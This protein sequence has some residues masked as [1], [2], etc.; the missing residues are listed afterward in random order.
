MTK[1]QRGRSKSGEGM[2][3]AWDKYRETDAEYFKYIAW[4]ERQRFDTRELV[5]N[6]P[7]FVGQVNLAR[8][9]MMYDLYA[10]VRELSG[11]IADIGTFKGASFLFFA[12]LVA[13]FERASTTQVHGFDWFRGMAPGRRDSTKAGQYRASYGMLSAMVRRQGLGDVA[14]LHRMDLVR[15]FSPFLDRN[16]QMRFKLSFVDCGIEAVLNAVVGPL[17][18]RTVPGGIMIF[19]HYGSEA[20]PTESAAVEA[21]IGSCRIR[22]FPHVRQATAYVIKE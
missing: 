21:V 19:D 15:Q 9:L 17:W 5:F 1:D 13:L 16:P 10:R 14:V 22:H 3:R 18:Q 4:L 7:V 11:N 20:S 6:Y 12:K 2:H 8:H